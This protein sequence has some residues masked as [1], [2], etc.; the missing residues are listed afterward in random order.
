MKWNSVNQIACPSKQITTGPE[1]PVVEI[2]ERKRI[3]DSYFKMDEYHLRHTMYNGEMSGVFSREVMERGHAVTVLPYD[4][5]L[6]TVVLI[7]QFRVGAYVA[8]WHPWMLEVAAGIIDEGESVEDVAK[9]EMIE[10]TGCEI[11]DLKHIHSFLVSSGCM[12]E[13]IAAY[14]GRVDST[15]AVQNAGLDEENEDIKVNVI[16]ANKAIEMLENQEILNSA[17]IIS[18]QWFKMNH[19][20]LRKEWL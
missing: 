3:C 13:T 15:K 6:D 17:A 1:K 11:L 4:P 7:E 2:V 20:K 5:V 14:C 19:E 9:R 16:S 8:D 10:E 12:S 18:L